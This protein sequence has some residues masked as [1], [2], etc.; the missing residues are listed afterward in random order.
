MMEKIWFIIIKGKKEG[1]YSFYDLR[2]DCR[3]TPDTF[4][5]KEG[6]FKWKKL[7][8]V[9]ELKEVFADEKNGKNHL[10]DKGN[11]ILSPQEEII[12][13]LQKEPPYLFWMLIILCILLYASLQLFWFK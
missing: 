4:V 1:P 11:L 13:D 6:F 10:I 3:I 8:D 7:R 9:P 2:R 12:L 5:W